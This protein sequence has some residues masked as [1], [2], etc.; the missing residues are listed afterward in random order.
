MSQ[1]GKTH[2]KVCLTILGL[3][4]VTKSDEAMH[5]ENLDLIWLIYKNIRLRAMK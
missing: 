5:S 2:F 4:A 1:N 3:V